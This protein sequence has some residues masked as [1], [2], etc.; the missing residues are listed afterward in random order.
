MTQKLTAL[1]FW[2]LSVLEYFEGLGPLALRL[3]LVPV[4]AESGWRKLSGRGA[5]SFFE[6]LGIPFPDFTAALTGLV[7]FGGAILLLLGLATRLISIPL[8]IVMLVAGFLVHGSNGWLTLSDGNSWLANERVMEAQPKKAEI[9]RI[10]KEHGDYS[11]LTSNGSI[12]IL[13]NGMQFAI[14]YFVMLLALLYTGGG[15]YVSLDYWIR[16]RFH[17]PDLNAPT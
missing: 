6:R 13:N 2:F 1:Y 12:T 3:F 5:G 10:V 11:Y 14:T 4:M 17:P 9:R 7:E 15:K 16:R 8:M